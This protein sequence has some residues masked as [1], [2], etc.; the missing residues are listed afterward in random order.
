[1][2]IKREPNRNFKTG[3]GSPG[4]MESMIKRYFTNF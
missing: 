4:T 2:F 3:Q 1:M